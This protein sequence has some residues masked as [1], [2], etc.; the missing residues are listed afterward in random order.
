MYE[1][2]KVY[3]AG[4]T[5]LIGSAV[6]AQ[7]AEQGCQAVTKSH[8]DLDLTDR[9]AVYDFVSSE[10]PDYVILAA[11]KVGGIQSNKKYPADYFHI[12]AAIQDNMFEA[13]LHCDVK[14]MVFYG[15]SCSYPKDCPQPIREDYLMTG[16]IEMTSQGYAAAKSEAS[17]PVRAIMSSMR[18]VNSSRWFPIPHMALTIILIWKMPMY[19][20]R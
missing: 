7:L 12:N 19:S 8:D 20:R 6:V 10:C 17:S 4:H 18:N 15:S 16:P 13:C 3:V 9:G 2:A 11:G 14:A 5:G 1:N